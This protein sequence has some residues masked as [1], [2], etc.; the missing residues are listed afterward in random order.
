MKYVLTKTKD[1]SSN[2]LAPDFA[3]REVLE[4]IVDIDGWIRQISRF[5][6]QTTSYLQ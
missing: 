1:G 5:Q 2:L 3:L 6:R 4:Q